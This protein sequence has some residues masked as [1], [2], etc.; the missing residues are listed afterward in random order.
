FNVPTNGG[1]IRLSPGDSF[2]TDNVAYVTGYPQQKIDVVMVTNDR[3]D[4]LYTAFSS[5]NEVNVDVKNPPMASLGDYDIVVF[6]NVRRDLIQP[7]TIR[8]AK[9]IMRNGGGV[10]IQAQSELP[11]ME[12]M[13]GNMLLV[14]AKDR[15]KVGDSASVV[16]QD[17]MIRGIEFSPPKE[18]VVAEL[19]AGR[20]L[21]NTS[22]N[23]PLLAV[24]QVGGGRALYYGFMEE[25]SNFKYNYLYPVF[26]KRAA[27]YLV[28]RERL[29]SINMQTGDTLSYPS[30]TTINTPTGTT[31][32]RTLIMRKTGYYSAN[33]RRV[34]ANL[35]SSAESDVDASQINTTGSASAT[36]GTTTQQVPLELTPFVALIALGIIA[37]ELLFLRYRGDI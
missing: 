23:S 14:D 27:Y 8:G 33:N 20:A 3:N 10:V 18:Y 11:Q 12:S 19:R 2:L 7:S 37:S 4:F 25:S 26:W 24:G 16:S 21:V 1:Q 31:T 9:E 32:A 36:G 29:S 28:G 22:D 13:Y 34:S 15:L 5:M 17:N 30:P 6:N 35:V